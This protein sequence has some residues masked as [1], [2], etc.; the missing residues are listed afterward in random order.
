LCYSS[1]FF[2]ARAVNRRDLLAYRTATQP[3]NEPSGGSTF[4]NPPDDFAARVIE[5]CGLKGHRVG[6]AMV[7]MKHANFI[8]NIGKCSAADIENLIFYVQQEVKK[9]KGIELIL[10]VKIVGELTA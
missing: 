2:S 9:Q 8:V 6:G 3:T 10:E 4:R 5:S 1:T 7:S